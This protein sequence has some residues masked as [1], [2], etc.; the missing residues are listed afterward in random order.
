MTGF[1]ETDQ[2][3]VTLEELVKAGQA[4]PSSAVEGSYEFPIPDGMHAQ[5]QTDQETMFVINSVASGKPLPPPPI[6]ARLAAAL[7]QPMFMTTAGTSIVT[8]LV[9]V[10]YLM[11]P[12]EAG[13]LESDSMESKGRMQRLVREEVKVQKKEDEKKA[14][15]EKPKDDPKAKQDPNI[16]EKGPQAPKDD[17]VQPTSSGPVNPNADSSKPSAGKSAGMLGVLSSMSANLGSMFSKDSA[18]GAEAEDALGALVGH[19]VGDESGLGGLGLGDGG[20]G[21]GGSGAGGVGFGGWGG[22]GKGGGGGGGGGFGLGGGGGGVGFGKYKSGSPIVFMSKATVQGG[23][24]GDTIRRVIRRHLQEIQYCYVSIGLPSNPKLEGLVKITF[25]ITPTGMV[26]NATVAQ[27]TL[28]HG[29]TEACI[30]GA[31]RRWK[32]PKPEGQMPY[33]TYPFHFKAKG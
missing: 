33:V 19:T 18:V 10:L 6:P 8:A 24:D 12:K 23:L 15:D 28:N 30:V 4:K 9:F 32:F 2:G 21:G 29:G 1:V 20:R 3:Q 5:V 7:T 22:F 11:T 27:S 26:G 14:K 17:R 13:S 16:K 25:T 31:V